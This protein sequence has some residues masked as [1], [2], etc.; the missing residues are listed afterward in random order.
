M[1]LTVLI[2]LIAGRA[3]NTLPLA[4][5]MFKC[6]FFDANYCILIKI[7]LKFAPECPVNYNT[8]LVLIMAWRR[9]S[10]KPLSEPM[11]TQLTDAYMH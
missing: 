5:E 11:M 1:T 8:T 6:F 7:S 4:D 9:M 10:D 2:N 3:L